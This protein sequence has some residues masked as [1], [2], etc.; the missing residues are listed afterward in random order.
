[1]I[2]RGRRHPGPRRERAA[3]P[4][5]RL[6][7]GPRRDARGDRVHALR[8][9]PR[10]GR[11]GG[12]R[13]PAPARVRRHAGGPQR[14]RVRGRRDVV[15]LA[16]RARG[17]STGSRSWRGRRTRTPTPRR[18]TARSPSSADRAG[19]RRRARSWSSIPSPTRGHRA[20]TRSSTRST[21]RRTCV[22]CFFQDVI[23]TRGRRARRPPDRRPRQPRSDSNPVYELD[24]GR[25]AARASSTRA[26]AR[27]SP[28]A[29][30]EELIARGCRAVRRVRRRRACSCPMSRSAT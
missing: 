12:R 17:S 6:A 18:P 24:A 3:E 14:Q 30:L 25:R 11:G 7:R 22:L 28:A 20:A 21:S 29:F 13:V 15:L 4:R 5:D 19:T 26:S 8:L 10:G 9:L 23:E 27:R 1:M 2:D 16:A